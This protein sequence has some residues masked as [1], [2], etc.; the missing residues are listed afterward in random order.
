MARMDVN[1]SQTI[2][3][4]INDFLGV[5]NAVQFSQIS[6]Q[7]SPDMLNLIPGK[8]RGLRHRAGSKLVTQTA[9]VGGLVRMFPYRASNVNNIVATGGTTLYKFDSVGL[10]WD[11]Q[12]MTNT[13]STADINAVQ[14]R[15]ESAQEILVISDGGSLK[16]YNGTAVANI[17][18]A[19]NDAAP[20]PANDLA[21]INS[22]NPAVG[23]TTHNNRLV[24]WPAGKDIIFHSKPGYN[25]YF[26]QTSFQRWVKDNDYIQTCISFGSALLVFMRNSIGVLFGD[27]YSTT[28]QATDWTQDF[29]DTSYGCVNPRSV[30]LVVFPDGSEQVF[31]QTERGVSAVVNIDT[32]S[33]DN[34]TRFS[35]RNVTEDK[36]DWNE[37]GLSNTEWSS[38]VSYFTEGKYWLIWLTGGVTKGMVYD[39]NNDQWYPIQMGVSIMD[40]YA[41]ENAFYFIGNEG[42]LKAFDDNKHRD[43]TNYA[44]TQGNPVTWYWYSKLMNPVLTGHDHFWDILMVESQQFSETSTIDVEINTLY[45]RYL[46][47]QAIKTAIMIVGVS[48]IGQAKIAN[49]NLS[50]II[51]NAERLRIFQ[52]GQYA[53]IK[54]SSDRGEPVELYNIRIEVRPQTTY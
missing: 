15:N 34:S 27:G 43:Y 14:F 18:P 7:Q 53:Q 33:L 22:S 13:L 24:I 49:A 44:Q 6:I 40:F 31:Y 29:L 35:T 5:N 1:G 4:E 50:D 12:T 11:A 47:S 41:N 52:K 46:Q 38:A 10:D 2:T 45:G 25:D 8:V 19:A 30:R 3:L 51:N 36:I 17:T 42:H 23:V 9:R 20:L 28:P 37:L 39:T 48:V 16:A 32:K 21:T 54:L 26:P